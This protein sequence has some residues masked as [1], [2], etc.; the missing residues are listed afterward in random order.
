MRPRLRMIRVLGTTLSA[1]LCLHASSARAQCTKDT[2]CKG[3]RVCQKGD[4]VDPPQVLRPGGI[5]E[6]APGPGA[7]ENSAAPGATAAPTVPAIPPSQGLPPALVCQPPAG[8]PVPAAGYGVRGAGSAADSLSVGPNE[9]GGAFVR[10]SVGLGYLR[11]DFEHD[12]TSTWTDTSLAGSFSGTAVTLGAAVGGP[13][14]RR[15]VVFVELLGSFLRDPT[16]APTGHPGLDS[17]SWGGT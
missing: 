16:A 15:L 13:I 12:Q 17:Q 11:S 10:L 9:S 4:C 3:E 2:D 6:P 7:P 8:N 5:A 1:L 14:S